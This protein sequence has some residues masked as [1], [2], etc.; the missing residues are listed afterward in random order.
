[1]FIVFEGID[2]VGKSSHIRGVANFLAE[3]GVQ[4]TCTSEFGN[5]QIGKNIRYILMNYDLTGR[6]ELFLINAIRSYHSRE[7]LAPSIKADQWILMD[8]FIDSTWAYQHGGK[9]IPKEVVQEITNLIDVPKPDL[10]VLLDGDS[11]RNIARDKFDNAGSEFFDRVKESYEERFDSRNWLRYN[12]NL[13]Y[14]PVQEMIRKDL[15]KRIFQS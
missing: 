7:V 10:V 6:E 5:L 12:T 11:H 8:R 15:R 9:Q 1:M 4:H 2:G 13:G 3:M 14:K